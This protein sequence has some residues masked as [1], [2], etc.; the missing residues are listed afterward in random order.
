M[1]FPP[2]PLTYYDLQ[3]GVQEWKGSIRKRTPFPY[4]LKYGKTKIDNRRILQ[5]K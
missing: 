1:T 3:F 5:L 4:R 2:K